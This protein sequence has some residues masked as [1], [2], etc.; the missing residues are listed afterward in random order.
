[1]LRTIR[2]QG[3]PAAVGPYSQAI[4]VNGFVYVS[5]QLPLDPST[6]EL[7]TDFEKAVKQTIENIIHVVT[8]SGSSIDRIVK[9]NVYLTDMS[10]FGTFN[11]I[12]STYFKDH[13]PARAVVEVRRLPK[14]A[15]LEIEAVAV[16]LD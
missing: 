13:R 3:A 12:Y 2:T 11:E 14:D 16:T 1:M 8:A 6:G 10:R 4:E 5:G 15:P 7:I 9:I